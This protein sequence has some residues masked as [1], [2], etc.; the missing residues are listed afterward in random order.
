MSNITS[1]S[2][3]I[4]IDPEMSTTT[5]SDPIIYTTSDSSTYRLAYNGQFIDDILLDDST[6]DRLFENKYFITKLKKFMFNEELEKL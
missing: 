1:T 3:T 4:T 5:I 6:I 2:N